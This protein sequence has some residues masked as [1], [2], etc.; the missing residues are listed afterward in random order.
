MPVHTIHL[1]N[2]EP[3]TKPF[4][5]GRWHLE[6]FFDAMTIESGP[7]AAESLRYFPSSYRFA[8]HHTFIDPGDGEVLV[9]EP[10]DVYDT[11]R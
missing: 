10:G 8:Q 5:W 11:W 7:D 9:I 4:G 6:R 1:R 3:V 2:G